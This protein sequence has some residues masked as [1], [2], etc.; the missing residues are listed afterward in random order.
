MSNAVIKNNTDARVEVSKEELPLHCPRSDDSLWDAHPRV[1]LDIE[2]S[3]EVKCP[4]CGA[5][6]VLKQS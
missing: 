4:Y 5:H 1:F 3:G 6:Y 2:V